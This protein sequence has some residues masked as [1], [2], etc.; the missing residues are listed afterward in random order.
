MA[1]DAKTLLELVRSKGDVVLEDATGLT[2]AKKL[3]SV[4]WNLAL[5][6]D[7]NCINILWGALSD[8]PTEQEQ[9]EMSDELTAALDKIYGSSGDSEPTS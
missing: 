4:I 5:G 1:N 3:S 6:G 7:R 9:V 8:I 2:A